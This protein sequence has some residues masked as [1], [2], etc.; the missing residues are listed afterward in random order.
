MRLYAESARCIGI[1]KSTMMRCSFSAVHG[2]AISVHG[3]VGYARKL[4]REPIASSRMA[5]DVREVLLW[6]VVWP[7]NDTEGAVSGR[8]ENTV[9]TDT[10]A[11]SKLCWRSAP[12]MPAPG[13]RSS[14]TSAR[15]LFC[16]PPCTNLEINP[17]T[18]AH[19]ATRTCNPNLWQT[20]RITS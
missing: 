6:I 15:L 20:L 10:L 1:Q 13:R 3:A 4:L 2:R 5:L 14:A 12:S 9:G 16:S 18:S 8:H 17:S 19:S 11:L 7:R